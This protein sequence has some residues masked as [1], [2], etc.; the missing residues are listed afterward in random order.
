VF[1]TKVRGPIDRLR[2][3]AAAINKLYQELLVILREM[4]L[5]I[6]LSN[7]VSTG[8]VATALLRSMEPPNAS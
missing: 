4:N 5:A 2:D 1:P 3:E 7:L 6:D 8:G